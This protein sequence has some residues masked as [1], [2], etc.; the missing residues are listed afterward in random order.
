M[1]LVKRKRTIRAAIRDILFAP[2]AFILVG[3]LSNL[4]WLGLAAILMLFTMW[5]ARE[6]FANLLPSRETIYLLFGVMVVVAVAAIPLA[7]R[8]YFSDGGYETVWQPTS[9]CLHATERYIDQLIKGN[10]PG[11]CSAFSPVLQAEIPIAEFDREFRVLTDELGWPLSIADHEETE[12]PDYIYNDP[13]YDSTTD[14]IVQIVMNHS[15][16]KQS[17]IALHLNSAESFQ[18]S[19]VQLMPIET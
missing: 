19:N 17:L 14:C 11:F 13:D 15:G 1:A 5:M 3:I 2:V 18:I 6:P 10:V 7:L 12:I 4:V 8:D 9:G 16:A